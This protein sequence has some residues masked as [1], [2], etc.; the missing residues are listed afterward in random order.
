MA[1]AEVGDD[2]HAGVEA[3]VAP[4]PEG[5]GA[6]AQLAHG[7]DGLARRLDRV[8]DALGVRAQL[9]PRLRRLQAAADAREERDAELG[10]QRAHLLADRRLREMQRFCSSAERPAIERGEEVFEL[11]QVQGIAFSSSR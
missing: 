3:R 11:L 2:V 7:D 10:L 1:V 5:G 4:D 6:A 9:P 8:Q